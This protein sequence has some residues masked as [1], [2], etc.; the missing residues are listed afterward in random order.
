VSTPFEPGERVLFLDQRG[1]RYLVRLEPGRTWHFHGGAVPLDLVIGA[2]EG[3]VVHSATGA[4]LVCFRPSLP[5][6]V[7][8][9]PRGAQVVYPKD[10]AAIVMFAD[11]FPGASVLEA[12][13]GSGALCIAL[14]RATGPEGRVVTYEVR[15]DFHAKAATNLEAFF[16]KVPAW[17]DARLGDLR[18][19]AG[20][21]ERFDRVILDMPEPWGVLEAVTQ[22]MT[23]G[24]ILCGFL[25]TT[26]QVQ[27]LVLSMERAGFRRVETFELLLRPWHVTERSVRPDHRMVGHTGFITVGRLGLMS[28]PKAED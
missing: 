21:G 16:G 19:V 11:V 13:T 22:A 7:L 4:S 9:M 20:T 25:P 27:T 8:K 2:E 18:E 24:G 12:G 14:C 3:T 28:L 1:R 10:L 15:E 5:D 23:P 6:F 26:G 17:L